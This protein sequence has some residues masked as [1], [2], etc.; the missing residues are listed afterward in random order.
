MTNPANDIIHITIRAV[1]DGEDKFEFKLTTL[2]KEAK[3][4]A[5]KHLD[6]DPP[7]GTKY[8]LAEKKGD[9]FRVLDDDKT[10]EAENVKN[11]EMLWLGTE[12]QVG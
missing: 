11:D 6:I 9:D 8:R 2:V 3:D 5:I 12:P 1:G 4:A 7:L 10:L